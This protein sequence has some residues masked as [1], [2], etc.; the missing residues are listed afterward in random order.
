MKKVFLDKLPKRGKVKKQINWE[1]CDGYIVHF[2]Y[3]TIE[4]DIKIKS[5]NKQTRKLTIEYNNKEFEINTDGFAKCALGELLKKNTSD[6]KIEI[7]QRFQDDKRDIIIIDR[8]KIQSKTGQWMKYY[9]YKCN[10]CGFNGGKHYN[11]KDKIYKEELWISEANLLTLNNGCACCSN[12]IVVESINSIVTMEPWMI[13]YFVEGYKEAKK[14]TCNS[15]HK[16][17]PICPECK[18]IQ[19]KKNTI[20]SVYKTHSVGCSCGDGKSFPEKFMSS[21]LSQ[22]NINP[23]LEYSPDWITPR[24]YDF[25]IES[26]N[27]IIETDGGFHTQDN[28]RN[29]QTKEESKAIDNYKDEQARLHGIEVIRIDCDYNNKDRLEYIKQNIL[30]NR[31]FKEMFDISKINW[32]KCGEFA[33]SNLV[34]VACEYKKNNPDLTTTDIGRVMG[35]YNK[36]TVAG[37]LKQGNGIWCNYDPKEEMKRIGAINGKSRRKPIIMFKNKIIL[38]LFE[39]AYEIERKSKSIFNEILLQGNIAM[40]ARGEKEKYKGYIFKY[41]KDLTPEE[42]IRYDVDNKIK[43]LHNKDLGQAC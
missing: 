25:Y 10:K 33:L 5:Y 13:E 1:I 32:N 37:W 11:P 26:M 20:S 3:K 18:K 19:Q 22:L 23:K 16:F 24:R 36:D 8:K 21:I 2:I 12:N 35:G 39:S 28:K 34:K 41:I 17:Y 7:G 14:Y 30:N 38:G 40:V 43:E 9:R 29:G 6:F 42:Y 31:R 15:S 4:G 27:L